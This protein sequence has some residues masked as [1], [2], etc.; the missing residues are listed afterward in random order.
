MDNGICRTDENG[1]LVVTG[2]EPGV[3]V[4][5]KQ[6]TVMDGYVLNGNPQIIRIRSGEAQNLTFYNEPCG[7]LVV[8]LRDKLTE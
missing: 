8:I 3:N 4:N 7:T 1:R 5:V 6:T 2:L